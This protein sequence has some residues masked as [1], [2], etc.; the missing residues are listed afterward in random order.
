M[1]SHQSAQNEQGCLTALQRV[2][3]EDDETQRVIELE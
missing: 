3:E 2:I 1:M